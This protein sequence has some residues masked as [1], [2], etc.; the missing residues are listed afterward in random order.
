MLG[1]GNSITSSEI[2]D[3]FT[4]TQI[5]NLK[6]WL[7]NGVGNTAARWDDSSGNSNHAE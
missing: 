4:P 3:R 7:Q 1:L 6:L 5:A 2:Y